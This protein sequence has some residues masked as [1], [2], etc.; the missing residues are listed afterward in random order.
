MEIGDTSTPI[1]DVHDISVICVA[2]VHIS[3]HILL[4]IRGNMCREEFLHKCRCDRLSIDKCINDNLYKGETTMMGS[5][6]HLVV[7]WTKRCIN[8]Q[9]AYHNLLD[10][11]VCLCLQ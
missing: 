3:V 9:K 1:R 5:C 8:M 6:N 11:Q 7:I 2:Y 4:P 10:R